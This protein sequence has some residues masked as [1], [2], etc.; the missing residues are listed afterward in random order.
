MAPQ[1]EGGVHR[2]ELELRARDLG[3]VGNDR[4][5]DDRPQE[6]GAA[7]K[8]QR[9]EAAAERVHEAIARGVV[10]LLGGDLV[11]V[12]VVDDV[13]QDLSG[14]GRTFEMAAV[15]VFLPVKV[16]GAVVENRWMPGR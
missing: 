5:R 7:G 2:V 16:I 6:L 11:L 13:D 1:V 12:D 9:L 3:A 8:L 10:G 15:M 4:A 14:S